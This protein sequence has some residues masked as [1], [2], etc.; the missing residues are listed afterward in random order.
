MR[1]VGWRALVQ[2]D[3][4]HSQRAVGELTVRAVE[5]PQMIEAVE[6]VAKEFAAAVLDFIEWA[7]DK[8]LTPLG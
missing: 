7:F 8:L 3:S 5:V 1:L 6:K 4:L 2:G